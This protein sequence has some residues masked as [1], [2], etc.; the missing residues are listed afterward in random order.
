MFLPFVF[1]DGTGL[2]M[3][4]MQGVTLTSS[5]PSATVDA[6]SST[7]TSKPNGAD[8]TMVNIVGGAAALGLAV[9]A[10]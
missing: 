6:T 2:L 7:S 5:S 1:L 8:S 4:M 10:L 9:L 3:N